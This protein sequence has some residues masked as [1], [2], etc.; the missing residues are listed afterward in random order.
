MNETRRNLLVGMFM[1]VGLGVLATLLVLFGERPSWLGGA[2]WELTIAFKKEVEGVSG[3]TQINLSGVQVGRVDRVEFTDPKRPYLGLRVIG[4]IKDEYSIPRQSTARVY[5]GLLG[6]GRG[7]IDI[8]AP[9]VETPPLVRQEA[10]IDG[11]MGN[12]FEGLIP[13]TLMFSVEKAVRQIGD[14]AERA[15]PLADDLRNLFEMRTVE[16]VDE[17]PVARARRITA[18]VYT[19]VQRFDD[20]LKHFNN[21]LG[22]PEVQSAFRNGIQDLR[23]AAEDAREMIATLRDTAVQVREDLD[24]IGGR[25]DSGLADANEGINE[26]R[27]RLIPALDSTAKLAENLNRASRALAQ[28][29]GTVGMLLHDARLYEAM[30]LSVERVT[31]AVDRIRRI[32]DRWE[33]QGYIELKAHEA[34]GPFPTKVKKPIPK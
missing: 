33:K 15:T 23:Q 27:E 26:I 2:E 24:R 31:D 1:I 21:V 4:L 5:A 8:I 18:N 29:E 32:L 22:D 19:V 3:G 20:T 17:D 34:V 13:E 25:V 14:L 16:E 28:G 30:L 12:P 10:R 6:L 7:R 9:E 11:E